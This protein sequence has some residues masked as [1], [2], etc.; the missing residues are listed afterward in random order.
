MDIV[1]NRLRNQMGNLWMN[2]CLVAHIEKHIF[3]S[4]ANEVVMQRLKSMKTL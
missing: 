2:D 4:I 3:S 1:K